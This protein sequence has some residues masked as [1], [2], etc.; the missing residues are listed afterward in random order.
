MISLKSGYLRISNHRKAQLFKYHENFMG[1]ALCKEH[2]VLIMA[3]FYWLAN[4][5][6]ILKEPRF[7]ETMGEETLGPRI[8]QRLMRMPK[9]K[10][11]ANHQS[12]RQ[13]EM[14]QSS[15]RAYCFFLVRISSLLN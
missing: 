7:L 1:N 2:Y 10:Q 3:S 14:M 11:L 8:H 13:Y 9:N 12:L 15:N 4:S 6:N 5:Q